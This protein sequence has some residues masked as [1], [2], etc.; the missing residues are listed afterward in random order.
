MMTR[1]SST[2]SSRQTGPIHR[3][4]L[5]LDTSQ[6]DLPVTEYKYSEHFGYD[7]FLACTSLWESS[8][9]VNSRL[10]LTVLSG[11]NSKMVISKMFAVQV[12]WMANADCALRAMLSKSSLCYVFV[13]VSVCRFSYLSLGRVPLFTFQKTLD[14][15]THTKHIAFLNPLSVSFIHLS[16]LIINH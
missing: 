10:P 9:S 2:L 13:S 4:V 5:L 15:L 12:L 16:L 1:C 7:H 3:S 14:V 11:H 6:F 8:V